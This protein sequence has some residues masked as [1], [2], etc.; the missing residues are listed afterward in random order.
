MKIRE[1]LRRLFTGNEDSISK[2]TVQ[3]ASQKTAYQ[4]AQDKRQMRRQR[5]LALEQRKNTPR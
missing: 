5:N 3:G 1:T 2:R 4:S